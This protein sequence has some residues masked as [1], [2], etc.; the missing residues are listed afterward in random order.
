MEDNTGIMEFY[1]QFS[2]KHPGISVRLS[3][4]TSLNEVLEAF[5]DFLRGAGYHFEGQLDFVE[6][7]VV[8]QDPNAEAN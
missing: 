8:P 2:D 7:T 6:Y 3:P 1:Y 5:E 4:E